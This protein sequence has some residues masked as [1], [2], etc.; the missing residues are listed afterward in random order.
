V[1]NQ[2]AYGPGETLTLDLVLI[3]GSTAGLVDGYVVLLLP[4]GT[5]LSVTLAGTLVPGLV[6]IATG[7]TPVAVSARLVTHA[8]TGVEP[9]GPYRI[10]A[11][12]TLPGTLTVVSNLV[13]LSFAFTP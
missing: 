12:L 4:D 5:P 6:P 8:F 9:P 11:G 13:D 2:A 1:L 3:P 10:L 7:F